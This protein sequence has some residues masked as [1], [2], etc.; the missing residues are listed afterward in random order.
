MT[1]SGVKGIRLVNCLDTSIVYDDSSF[2]VTYAEDQVRVAL[3]SSNFAIISQRSQEVAWESRVGR[4]RR[5]RSHWRY[6][7]AY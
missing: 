7:T 1:Q 6:S 2:E 5:S 4:H 3:D